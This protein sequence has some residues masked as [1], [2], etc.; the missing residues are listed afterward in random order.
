MNQVSIAA[1]A[2]A[3]T[4]VALLVLGRAAEAKNSVELCNAGN[5]TLSLVTVTDGPGGGWAIDGWQSIPVGECR[6]VDTIFKLSVGFAVTS[7]DGQRGMQVYDASIDPAAT[8]TDSSYCVR[9]TGAFHSRRD[10]WLGL[11]ECQAG[12]ALARFAFS[13]KL[14]PS[15]SVRVHIPADENGDIIPFQ[16]PKTSVQSF[17]PFQ[18]FHR[19][20]PP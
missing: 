6:K 11:G 12:E 17:P 3:S 13:F 1:L 14:V 9:P 20:L 7:A 10:R 5:T 2:R 4:V 19:L 15:R 8:P 16:L 18:P